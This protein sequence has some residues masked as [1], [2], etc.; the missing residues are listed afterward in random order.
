MT[1]LNGQYG[2]DVSLLV[3]VSILL[4]RLLSRIS[5]KQANTYVMDV[6]YDA[7]VICTS[8]GTTWEV[9]TRAGH[10][11]CTQCHD[12]FLEE[13]RILTLQ[14]NRNQKQKRLRQYGLLGDSDTATLVELKRM[15]DRAIEEED[16]EEAARIRDRIR[17]HER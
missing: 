3:Q 1:E 8:C 13:L 7:E 6:L 15:L 12:L 11:G 2:R 10:L 17:D 16:Y 5:K 9:F 4:R 14:L